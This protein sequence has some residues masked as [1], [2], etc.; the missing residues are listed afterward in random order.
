MIRGRLFRRSTAA[1]PGEDEY[2]EIDPA[3]TEFGK[4]LKRPGEKR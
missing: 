2:I 3:E 4:I 1:E